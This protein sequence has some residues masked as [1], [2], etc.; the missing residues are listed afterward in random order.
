MT[1]K[2][3]NKVEGMESLFRPKGY[4]ASTLVIHVSLLKKGIGYNRFIG[5]GFTGLSTILRANGY[6]QGRIPWSFE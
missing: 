1:R 6:I 4:C 3:L 5:V 2:V